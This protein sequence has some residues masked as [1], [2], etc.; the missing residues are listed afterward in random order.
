MF[1]FVHNTWK[2]G[3]FQTTKLTVLFLLASLVSCK[4]DNS[5]THPDQGFPEFVI[6]GQAFSPMTCSGNEV[7]VEMYKLESGRLLEDVIDNQPQ[8]GQPFEGDFART[9]SRSDY[10]SVLNLFD[11]KIPQTLLN[12]ES[13]L[14]YTNSNGFGSI[15]YFEYKSPTLHRYWLFNTA[16][17]ASLPTDV[18][19]FLSVLQN[20]INEASF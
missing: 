10:D 3:Q 9:L 15:L 1:V 2:V 13:G 5:A 7:C 4:K 8:A 12:I 19:E 20:A 16:E 17:T 14:Y 6:F 11:N 18:Q